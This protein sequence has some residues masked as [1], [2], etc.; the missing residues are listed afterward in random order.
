M[1]KLIE[2]PDVVL[3]IGANCG[4]FSWMVA[5]KWP[6]AEVHAIEPAYDL[7]KSLSKNCKRAGIYIHQLALSDIN[8]KGILFINKRSQQTNSLIK[9]NVLPF[10][11]KRGL[12]NQT[13]IT[14]TLDSFIKQQKI[15]KVD[16]IKIDIQGAEGLVFKYGS[17]TL[18]TVKQLFLECTWLDPLS[19]VNL[20][21][22]MKRHGFRYCA[23]VN[24]VDYGADL[25]I[26]REPFC[27][28][29]GLVSILDI[30]D[31]RKYESIV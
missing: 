24:S 3:D 15:K 7:Q 23:A 9:S 10:V 11:G 22:F 20:V 16:I 18:S 1:V 5:K 4:L 31:I 27:S 6:N 28:D 13:V 14:T 12:E 8:G 25:L 29:V 19:V 30:N 26:Q 2:S 21:P 17:D